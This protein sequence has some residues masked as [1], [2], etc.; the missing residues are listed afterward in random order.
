MCVGIYPVHA[1]LSLP[2]DVSLSLQLLCGGLTDSPVWGRGVSADSQ[3]TTPAI[4]T[5]LR[6][7]FDVA[8][9]AGAVAGMLTAGIATGAL[10]VLAGTF[11]QMALAAAAAYWAVVKLPATGTTAPHEAQPAQ[12]R[13]RDFWVF[14]DSHPMK[15]DQ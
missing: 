8:T 9:S 10:G 12:V 7:D 1:G 11:S 3:G 13:T 5:Q 14:L 4:A 15:P 6:N 2:K